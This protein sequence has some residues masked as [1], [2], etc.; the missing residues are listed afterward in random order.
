MSFDRHRLR[1]FVSALGL[2]LGAALLFNFLNAPLPWMTGPLFA[3]AIARMA[4]WRLH[5]LSAAQSAGQW[6]IGT[7]LGLYFT[8]VVTAVVLSYA[9]YI[10]AGALFAMV[11]TVVCG[12]LL[13]RLCEVDRATAFYCMAVGGASEMAVQGE[14]AGASGEKIAAAHALRILMVV[15]IIPFAF[16]FA[17]VHG[18]D[19]YVVGMRVVEPLGLCVLV[20]LSCAGAL[21]VSRLNWP[22]AWVIGP[23]LVSLGLTAAGIE[24][25]A[26]PG[27]MI[28][29]GQLFIGIALGTR[30]SPQFIH[31]APR[32]L[33]GVALCCLLAILLAVG[34]GLLMAWVSPIPGPTAILAT[35]PG[36]I[37]EMS[38]TAKTLQLGVPVVTAFH[39]TRLCILVMTAG[40]LY[41]LLNGAAVPP[42]A[43]A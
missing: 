35:A 13:Q 9:A 16:K 5:C 31:E 32:F 22:N 30:F 24:L 14:R 21:L 12:A 1:G 17:D 10:A 15:A 43:E 4:G 18:A 28:A 39:V 8:P 11:L 3:T 20:L 33:L 2:G 42:E 38:L 29:L 41:K 6:A 36:G 40:P 7:A 27:W 25:S 23:L 37:A 34:F 26:L 19:P